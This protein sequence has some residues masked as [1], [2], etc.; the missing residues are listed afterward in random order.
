MLLEIL[1]QARILIVD[2]DLDNINLL[3]NVMQ[4]GGFSQVKATDDPRGVF[5]LFVEFEPDL[6]IL[7]LNMPYQRL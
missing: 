2:D 5:A 4:V 6:I 1:M 3:K 7:D